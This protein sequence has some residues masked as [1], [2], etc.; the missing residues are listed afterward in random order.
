MELG[1]DEIST[2]SPG[3]DEAP[4]HG[5]VFEEAV[6]TH[7]AASHTVVLAREGDPL[8]FGSPRCKP[9]ASEMERGKYLVSG[10][11]PR[12]QRNIKGGNLRAAFVEF[13]AVNIVLENR[14]NCRL[15]T[16]SLFLHAQTNEQG[17]GKY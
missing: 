11:F 14:N 4:E 2:L 16:E 10:E 13:Q 12:R 8:R 3:V 6:E 7:H 5:G 15:R 9:G 17:Q 1:L